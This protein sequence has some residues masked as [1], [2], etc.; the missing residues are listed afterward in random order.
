MHADERQ[1]GL[2]INISTLPPS[3]YTVVWGANRQAAGT[4]PDILQ[5]AVLSVPLP[6]KVPRI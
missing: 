4:Y 6:S 3:N 2:N 5:Y 1:L